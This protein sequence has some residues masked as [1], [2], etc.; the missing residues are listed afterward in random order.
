M[1]SL[2]RV[3]ATLDNCVKMGT[4]MPTKMPMKKKA[5]A[6]RAAPNRTRPPV[7]FA[8][9]KA[10]VIEYKN[11]SSGDDDDMLDLFAHKLTGAPQMSTHADLLQRFDPSLYAEQST[12]SCSRAL[13]CAPLQRTREH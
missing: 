13:L 10:K 6:S 4:K 1:H 3:E 2:Q 11:Y 7:K 12:L 9:G 5:V 8:G